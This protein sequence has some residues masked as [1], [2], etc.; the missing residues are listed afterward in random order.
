[1][2]RSITFNGTD[3]KQIGT[4]IIRR[5]NEMINEFDLQYER[6]YKVVKVVTQRELEFQ[7]FLK[8]QKA[9]QFHMDNLIKILKDYFRENNYN[10]DTYYNI[11]INRKN[12]KSK[13][14]KKR[15][16]RVRPKTYIV[17]RNKFLFYKITRNNYYYNMFKPYLYPLTNKDK[18]EFERKIFTDPSLKEKEKA[19]LYNMTPV[20][21]KKFVDVFGFM[22]S[23]MKKDDDEEDK[24]KLTKKYKKMKNF[25]I[26][27]LFSKKRKNLNNKNQINSKREISS[28][29]ARIGGSRNN[30]DNI[31]NFNITNI[32]NYNLKSNLS[33]RN[34]KN[35]LKLNN[36]KSVKFSFI[37][38]DNNKLNNYKN[39]IDNNFLKINQPINNSSRTI[40]LDHRR[41]NLNNIKLNHNKYIKNYNLNSYFTNLSNRTPKLSLFNKKN[42]NNHTNILSR[43]NNK[44]KIK[45][46][47]S[48]E[49]LKKNT[50]SDRCIKTIQKSE[51]LNKDIKYLNKLYE[52]SQDNFN[53]KKN[54]IENKTLRKINILSFM[55]IYKKEFKPEIKKEIEKKY[56]HIKEDNNGHI[57]VN[58]IEFIRKPKSKLDFVRIYNKRR[59]QK[60]L[61]KIDFIYNNNDEE[62]SD[63]TAFKIRKSVANIKINRNKINRFKHIYSTSS[64]K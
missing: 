4:P 49:N 9:L 19:K 5:T 52:I 39:K 59:D 14:R 17:R 62:K 28:K 3:K 21:L 63:L 33:M 58:K 57:Q 38:N 37:N 11:F 54:Q 7:E 25:S 56:E 2:F 36:P 47:L 35:Y 8:Q 24:E 15:R 13:K 18:K 40:N 10:E 50:F 16:K 34:R 6:N 48:I 60:R 30:I 43:D 64:L 42:I 23:I 51:V 29:L 46:N 45:K 31:K 1:M 44:I 27:N 12:Q 26:Y 41:F 32:N 20:Q 53:N 22:P 61:N 55:Q